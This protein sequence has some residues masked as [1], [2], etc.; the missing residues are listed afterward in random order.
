MQLEWITN[1]H[2]LLHITSL[3][4]LLQFYCSSPVTSL[5]NVSIS[6]QQYCQ[7]QTM[8][9]AWQL[10][11]L[12]FTVRSLQYRGTVWG[13]SDTFLRKKAI[14]TADNKK[15]QVYKL[16]RSCSP[17]NVLTFWCRDYFFFI[18]AHPVYKM[19]IIQES[20][21][22]ELWNKLHFEFRKKTESI[23]HV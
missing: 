11:N 3:Q 18:L 20:N 21:T 5:N 10:H 22:L 1:K 17:G 6:A 4:V 2:Q 19:W 16:L 7:Y 12:R 8:Q 14:Y 13:N 9:M 23:Y 15:L